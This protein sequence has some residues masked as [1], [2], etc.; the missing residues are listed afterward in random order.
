MFYTVLQTSRGVLFTKKTSLD[1]DLFSHG[2]K[3]VW[4]YSVLGDR[5]YEMRCLFVAV[6]PNARCLIGITCQCHMPTC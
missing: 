4:T 1:P 5:I 6:G 2:G 3:Q